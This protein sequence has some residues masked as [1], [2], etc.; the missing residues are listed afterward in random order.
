MTT[1]LALDTSNQ[2]CS[3]ALLHNG[4]IS[5][6]HERA[7][8]QHS[9]VVLPMVRQVLDGAGIDLKHV[10]AFV[11][12]I[13]PGGFTGVRLAVAVVQGL[14]FATRKLVMP[15]SSLLAMAQAVYVQ[16]GVECVVTVAM[17]ARMQEVYHAT[18]RV[19]ASGIEEL[20]APSLSRIQDFIA[21]QNEWVHDQ[22]FGVVGNAMVAF[23]QLVDWGIQHSAHVWQIDHEAPH[24]RDLL[25]AAQQ[26]GT[27]G[28][29]IA[30]EQIAPLYVRDKIAQTIAERAALKAGV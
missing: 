24:A 10:D 6:L 7:E 5:E 9:E 28:Q 1:L 19:N 17:D 14:A 26:L 12:G 15:L 11:V 2:F 23:Q 8:Q 30:P 29:M 16:Q 18:Y 25:S 22:N 4:V 13:G 27:N 3:V 20:Q 21:A